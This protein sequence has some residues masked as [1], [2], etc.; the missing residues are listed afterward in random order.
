V[1]NKAAASFSGNH[2]EPADP[3]DASRF[4]MEPAPGCTFGNESSFRMDCAQIGNRERKMTK[5]RVIWEF[6]NYGCAVQAIK[7]YLSSLQWILMSSVF[8]VR[9]RAFIA[10]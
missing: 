1:A 4:D 6:F 8:F 9:R 5:S 10:R 3:S 7:A 2:R